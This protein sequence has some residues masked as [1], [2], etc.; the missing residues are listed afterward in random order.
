MDIAF[1]YSK[2]LRLCSCSY[3]LYKKYPFFT[4]SLRVCEYVRPLDFE[5]V[6]RSVWSYGRTY[7]LVTTHLYM[8]S[9]HSPNNQFH[10]FF[11]QL[12]G[13]SI[14][15]SLLLILVLMSF[16]LLKLVSTVAAVPGNTKVMGA[17]CSRLGNLLVRAWHQ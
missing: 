10:F 5:E 2:P 17:L 4:P 1:H 3:E 16:M 11:T 9:L 15:L 14:P 6:R 7:F 13:P 8:C 12:S